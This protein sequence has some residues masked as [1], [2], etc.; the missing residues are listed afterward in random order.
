M[1]KE[2]IRPGR[3][4][5]GGTHSTGS[6]SNNQ[7]LPKGVFFYHHVHDCGSRCWKGTIHDCETDKGVGGQI[8]YEGSEVMRLISGDDKQQQSEWQN[9]TLED[10]LAFEATPRN[11]H[12]TQLDHPT[13]KKK[14]RGKKVGRR[15]NLYSQEWP[16]RSGITCR[17]RGAAA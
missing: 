3:S 2:Q 9:V 11:A 8:V 15:E 7:S 4:A 1:S 17:Q 13:R 16:V 5:G 12:S 6:F 14:R 10:D